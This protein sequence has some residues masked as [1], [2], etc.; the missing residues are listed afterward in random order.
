MTTMNKLTGMVLAMLALSACSDDTFDFG[1]TLTQQ[2]D[3]LTLSKGTYIIGNDMKTVQADSVLLRSSHCFLGRVKDPET[4]AYVSSEFMTQFNVLDGFSLPKESSIASK[5]DDV[6]GADSCFIDLFMANATGITDTLAALK[7][8]MAE[9]VEPM[10]ENARYYSNYDLEAEGKLRKDGLI[11]DKM[12]SYNDLTLKDSV[13][14]V[15][16]YY[17]RIT[18]KLKNEKYKAPDG[19]VYNNYGTYLM[20]QYYRHPEYFTNSYRFVNHVCPGFYFSVLDGEG[21]Y[22]EIVDMSIRFFYRTRDSKDSITT[23]AITL[24]GTEEVLQTTR[25]TNETDILEEMAKDETCTYIKAPAGLYTQVK[26]PID[27][28]FKGHESD[29]IMGANV[30]FQRVNHY[31]KDKSLVTPPHVLMLPADS[32]TSF[33]EKKKLTDNILSYYTSY[34]VGSSYANQYTFG[35]ISNLITRLRKIKTQGESTNPN[36]TREHPNWDKVLLV[37]IQLKTQTT[38]TGTTT[39]TGIEHYI[40]IASTQLVGGA[41]NSSYEPVKLNIVY[42]HFNE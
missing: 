11:V 42:G 19:T 33:F 40:G 25:I 1:K 10:E 7:L 2:E 18:F 34:T 22:T 29:S 26:L 21:V 8:R 17:N 30:S 15:K 39:V 16:N 31:I 41:Q 13:R 32:L 14:N 4:G 36:W 35:N 27:D 38:G 9:L 3:Q 28:I 20:Q 6:A 24:A 23:K 5:Y 12:F 37:P